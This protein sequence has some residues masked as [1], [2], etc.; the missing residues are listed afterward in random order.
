MREI[1][2]S[3][4]P[5]PES[6]KA[7]G[8]LLEGYSSGKWTKH[9]VFCVLLQI[10]DAQISIVENKVKPVLVVLNHDAIMIKVLFFPVNLVSVSECLPLVKYSSLF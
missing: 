5:I 9:F 7:R 6:A 8:I 10:A 2:L 1:D 4:L 3:R